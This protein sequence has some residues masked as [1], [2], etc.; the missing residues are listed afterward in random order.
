MRKILLNYRLS[1]FNSP[2]QT[3]FVKNSARI[4]SLGL[5]FLFFTMSAFAQSRIEKTV[6]V[7]GELIKIIPSLKD[8]IPGE[9]STIIT[10]TESGLIAKKTWQRSFVDYGSSAK[11]DPVVQGPDGLKLNLRLRKYSRQFLCS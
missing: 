10:R 2:A 5:V 6:S 8:W 4:L 9:D 3:R 7:V 11:N 1:F